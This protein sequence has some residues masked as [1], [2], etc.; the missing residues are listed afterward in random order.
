MV[1]IRYS[2]IFVGTHF[3]GLDL[4]DPF[5]GFKFVGFIVSLHQTYKENCYFISTDV[6]LT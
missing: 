6:R 5:M 4:N 3:C 1:E 2:F